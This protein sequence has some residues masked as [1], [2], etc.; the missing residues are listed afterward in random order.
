MFVV[1]FRHF[2]HGHVNWAYDSLPEFSA[3]TLEMSGLTDSV[4][5]VPGTLVE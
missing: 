5:I 2:Y 1:A 4:W 3:D